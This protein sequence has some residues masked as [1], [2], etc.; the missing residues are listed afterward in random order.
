[1]LGQLD[2]DP[3][4]LIFW[5]GFDCVYQH[6]RRNGYGDIP[7]NDYLFGWKEEG[8][9]LIE[10]IASTKSWKPRKQFYEHEQIMRFIKPGAVRIEATGSDNNLVVNAFQ[11]SKRAVG[12]CRS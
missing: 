7:P 8:K 12:D 9:P 4:A 6:G 5:D 3:K 11:Q 10:Y 2:D 1:M